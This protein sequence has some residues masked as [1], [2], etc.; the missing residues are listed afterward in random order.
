MDGRARTPVARATPAD[1]MQKAADVGPAPMHV[2]AILLLSPAAGFDGERAQRLLAERI[3]AVPRLRQRLRPAPPGCGRP[4]WSDDPRFD[5]RNHI[6]RLPCPAPGD[7]RALLD[8][9]MA[10]I[11]GPLPRSRPLWAATFVTGLADG[12]TALVIVMDHVLADGIGGLAALSRLVDENLAP[13]SEGGRVRFPTPA[14]TPRALAADA[15]AERA[16]RLMHLAGSVRTIRQGLGELA[17]ARPPRRFSPTS[18]NRACG[19]RRRLDVVAVDLEA[20]RDLGHACGGTVNDVILAAVAGALR[21]LLASRGE[22]LDL[23][24]VSV[25]VSA[26]Q[27][28]TVASLGNRV[29]AMLVTLSAVGSLPDRV[30]RAA[31]VTRERKR[32]VRGTSVALLAPLFRLLAA[33]GLARWYFNHQRLAHT[34][35]TDLRGPA[36][37]LTFAG[38]PLRAVLPVPQ[39]AGNISVTF[40]ALSYAGTLWLTVLSDPVLVPDAAE[41]AAALRRELDTVA[42]LR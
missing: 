31:A 22:K 30:R 20:V 33:A 6:L 8:V 17:A 23:V 5:V 12:G 3:R 10:V 29:G 36:D 26:R 1:L 42:G 37:P 15:W 25:P 41:L 19:P 14:P 2:G 40:A 27:S 28:D 35:V 39:T 24:T 11:T 4:F 38:A 34:F 21:T 18:L 13:P 32:P 7:E 16:N 9:A